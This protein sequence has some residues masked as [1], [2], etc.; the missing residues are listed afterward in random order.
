[1]PMSVAI[2]GRSDTISEYV[3]RL[4]SAIASWSVT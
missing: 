1:M 3:A 4:S 2:A